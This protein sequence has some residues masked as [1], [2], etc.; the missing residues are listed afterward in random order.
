MFYHYLHQTPCNIT[1]NLAKNAFSTE[2]LVREWNELPPSSYDELQH[3]KYNFINLLLDAYQ[4]IAVFPII[5]LRA[6]CIVFYS[7]GV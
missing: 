3:F 6:R 4:Y 5:I 1:K 7:P 2:L